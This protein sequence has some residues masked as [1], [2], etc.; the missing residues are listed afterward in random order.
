MKPTH[1]N[2]N[3]F[4]RFQS[5]KITNEK[6]LIDFG[7]IRDDD[8][9]THLFIDKNYQGKG[10]GKQLLKHLLALSHS[11]NVRLRASVNAVKFYE[12]QGFF[13]TDSEK[14]TLGI[15]FVPMCYKCT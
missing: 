6:E 2:A 4:P 12:A 3:I 10:L 11:K 5:L 8:C 1:K 15:R 14:Q 7:A 9:I 13:A